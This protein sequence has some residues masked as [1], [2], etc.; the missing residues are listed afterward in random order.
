MK[1]D[2]DGYTVHTTMPTVILF[3]VLMFLSGRGCAQKLLWR[4]EIHGTDT[5]AVGPAG[6][7]DSAFV[8]WSLRGKKI[9]E[10]SWSLIE[11]E[12]ELESARQTIEDK[13]AAL[14]KKDEAIAK[15]REGNEAIMDRARK[16]ERKVKRRKPWMFFTLGAATLYVI[17]QQAK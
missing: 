15:L 1:A 4:V 11:R 7:I 2:K 5:V 6:D 14:F 3:A 17:Q 10:C 13:N 12:K 16:A 8:R 9:R